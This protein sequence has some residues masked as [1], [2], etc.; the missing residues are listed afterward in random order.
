METWK[1]I[2]G[3]EGLYEVSDLGRVKGLRRNKILREQK[4]RHGYLSVWLYKDGCKPI[5]ASIHRLVAN[6]FCGEHEANAEVN[7]INEN[8]AD[9]RASNLEWLTH[10][11]NTNFGT[12]QSRRSERIRNNKRSTPV[13]QYSENGELIKT[14]PSIGQAFR[15]TGYSQGNIHRAMQSPSRRAYGYIWIPENVK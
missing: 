7:H 3:Y 10:K 6:A 8:K 13:S 15:E 12:A 11:E 2:S 1:P 9:N 5:Q 14:Y 4:R